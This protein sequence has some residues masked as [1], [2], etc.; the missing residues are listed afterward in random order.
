MERNHLEA[1]LNDP[2]ST[3]EE[4]ALARAELDEAATDAPLAPQAVTLLR[5]LG[6]ER[7]SDLTHADLERY[8][9]RNSV[10][11]DEPICREFSFWIAPD[12]R[13]LCLLVGTNDIL[14]A[15]RWNWNYVLDKA[16][17]A[18]RPDVQSHARHKL[19]ELDARP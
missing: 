14:A 11:Y 9:A 3:E 17:A 13:L 6:R 1:I 12:D 19:R 8:I 2:A 18:D 7:I 4:K 10:R 16:V 15:R 5:T